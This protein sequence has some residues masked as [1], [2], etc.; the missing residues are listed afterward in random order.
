M[1]VAPTFPLLGAQTDLMTSYLMA[2]MGSFGLVKGKGIDSG[3]ALSCPDPDSDWSES[4]SPP[5]AEEDPKSTDGLSNGLII[6][7]GVPIG[8][9]LDILVFNF[10]N[11]GLSSEPGGRLPRSTEHS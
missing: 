6:D 5:D 2:S 1:A 7:P 8:A 4:G 3:I 11:K 10:L 9:S